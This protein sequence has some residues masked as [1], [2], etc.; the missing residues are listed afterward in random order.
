VVLWTLPSNTLSTTHLRL[1]LITLTKLLKVPAFTLLPKELVKLPT[2]KMSQRVTSMLLRTL[3][4]LVQSLLPSKPIKQLSNTTPPVL[5]PLDAEPISIT[6]SSLSDMVLI[7]LVSISSSLRTNGVLL[8]VIKVT[9]KLVL[10]QPTHAVSSL[11]HPSLSYENESY[12][13]SN[14]VLDFDLLISLKYY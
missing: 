4:S 12:L 8:G 1:L 13:T 5:L 9:S 2:I 14:F 7:Q 3:F 11:S 6:V 10:T